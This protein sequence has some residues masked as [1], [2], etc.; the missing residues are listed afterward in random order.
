MYAHDFQDE[1]QLKYIAFI[2]ELAGSEVAKE[3]T[4]ADTGGYK[5]VK[6][7]SRDNMFV[8][9]LNRPEKYNAINLDVSGNLFVF[10]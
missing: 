9:T 3:D 5:T 1:A 10:F 2:N 7:E 8:I 4:A 6:V